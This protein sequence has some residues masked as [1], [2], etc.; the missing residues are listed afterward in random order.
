MMRD[1][2]NGGMQILNHKSQIINL[3]PRRAGCHFC[4]GDQLLLVRLQVDRHADGRRRRRGRFL[5]LPAN[6]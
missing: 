6:G 5:P 2:K 1:E 3:S 4:A